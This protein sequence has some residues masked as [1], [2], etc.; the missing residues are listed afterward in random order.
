MFRFGVI[1]LFPEYFESPMKVSLLG[2]ALESKRMEI[3]FVN[4]REFAEDRFGH[5]DDAPYGGGAGMIMQPKPLLEAI[6]K[7]KALLEVPHPS[8][9]LLSAR[10]KRITQ[11]LL[12]SLGIPLAL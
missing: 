6:Q 2:K 9:V 1:T 11:P 3:S 10:G 8:V 12:R 5:V 4:P 7:A